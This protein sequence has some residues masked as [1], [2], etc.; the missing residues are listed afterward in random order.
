MPE[1]KE[2]QSV[3]TPVVHSIYILS[4]FDCVE[5]HVEYMG[6]NPETLPGCVWLGDMDRSPA[7]FIGI[8]WP[9]AILGFIPS[10][11]LMDTK[12]KLNCLALVIADRFA[13][14]AVC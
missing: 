14:A 6:S 4:Y 3:Q 13:N 11:W 2:V 9:G 8:N 12:G 7:V 5:L 10:T 1:C